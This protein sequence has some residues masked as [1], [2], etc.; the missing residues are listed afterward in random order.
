MKRLRG[1]VR[2]S[3]ANGTFSAS[4]P[5]KVPVNSHCRL[6]TPPAIPAWSRIGRMT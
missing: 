3:Q 4:M 1:S 6:F 2:T 5:S